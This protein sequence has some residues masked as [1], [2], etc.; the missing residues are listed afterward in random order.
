MKKNTLEKMVVVL[1]AVNVVLPFCRLVQTL[2]GF[3][4]N[5]KD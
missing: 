2:K 1:A 3:N 5:E 4:D